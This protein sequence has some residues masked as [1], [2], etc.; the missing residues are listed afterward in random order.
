MKTKNSKS[1]FHQRLRSGHDGKIK[2]LTDNVLFIDL[3]YWPAGWKVRILNV[4]LLGVR[5]QAMGS[6]KME[7]AVISHSHI[8]WKYES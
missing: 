2:I 7:T 1:Q 5:V 4:G 3:T 6:G 8:N